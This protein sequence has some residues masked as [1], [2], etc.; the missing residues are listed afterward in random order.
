V[1]KFNLGWG[2]HSLDDAQKAE[3]VS[4]SR[5]ILRVLKEN[6]KTGFA[7]IITGDESWFDFEYPHQSIILSPFQR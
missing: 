5:D 6:Q 3:R 2:R 1:K 7:N 4:L